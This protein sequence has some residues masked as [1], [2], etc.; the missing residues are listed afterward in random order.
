MGEQ[1]SSIEVLSVPDLFADIEAIDLEAQRVSATL[2]RLLA[3][4]RNGS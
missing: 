1:S 2:R 3:R 4:V